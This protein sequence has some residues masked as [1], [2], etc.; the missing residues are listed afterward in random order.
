VNPFTGG[1]EA[2]AVAGFVAEGPDGDGGVV[3]VA[4]EHA[5]G[6][7]EVGGGPFG[8]VAEGDVGTVA[9]TVGF[10]VGFVNEVEAVFVAE[11]VPAGDVGVVAGADG[12]D[13][14]L[15]HELDVAEHGGFGDVMAG[16]GVVFVAVDAFEVDGDAVEEELATFDLD[17]A[18]AYPAGYGFIDCAMSIIFGGEQ[19]LIK[20]RI[21]GGP[22]LRIFDR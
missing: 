18:E 14:V 20:V 6:A 1:F 17:F 7:V 9:Y 12:V 3:F 13:V 10:D 4:F 8:F 5:D 2:D 16:V 22:F 11:F 19:D 21:F 15:F